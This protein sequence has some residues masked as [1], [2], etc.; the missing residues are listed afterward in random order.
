ML[1]GLPDLAKG[2]KS[3]KIV[4]NLKITKY[5]VFPICFCQRETFYF[6]TNLINSKLI[7]ELV[8]SG[9]KVFSCINAT[10]V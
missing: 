9:Y 6:F 8:S 5:L 3:S 2:R 1:I 7:S 4:I 10:Q